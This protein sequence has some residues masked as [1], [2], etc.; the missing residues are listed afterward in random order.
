MSAK[1][2]VSGRATEKLNSK[3]VSKPK[4]KRGKN[5][6]ARP[7]AGR[8]RGKKDPHTVAREATKQAFVDRIHH[9]ADQLLNAAMNVALGETYLMRKV[10]VRNS[11]G[12]VTRE[13]HETVTDP[14][15][16]IEYLDSGQSGDFGDDDEWYYM[17]TKPANVNAIKELFDRA[18]GKPASPD[19]DK[20]PALLGILIDDK[21][22]EQLIRIRANRRHL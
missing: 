19:D 17:T 11:K 6:G 18:F 10:T 5:G 2:P 12:T 20:G 7:G 15:K 21:Q 9:N 8:P 1:E 4:P 14:A 22:A 3:S 16:I 13:Y